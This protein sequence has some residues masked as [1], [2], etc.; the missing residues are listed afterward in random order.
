MIYIVDYKA[1]N[2]TS[3]QRALRALG[4][5]SALTPDPDVI[6]RADRVIF[7]GVGA[8]GAAMA[9]LRQ[10]G[11]D[12]ALVDA[13][14]R[15]IP[16]LGIC[17]GAQIILDRSEEGNTECV[18]LLPGITR[19]FALSDPMLKIPHMG[20]NRIRTLRH[21]PLLEGIRPEDEFYFV[22]SFYPDPASA[23]DIVAD[24]DYGIAFPVV[25]GRDNL[26]ATQ[27]HLEKSG[28]LGLRMLRN[29]VDWDGTV[30]HAQ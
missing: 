23:G 11:L 27:F 24:C 12:Q 29:F 22:H 8:A 16:I 26:I 4:V 10:T 25:I 3:V 20:W 14:A 13:R 15:G 2:V 5:E 17:L 21:H 9:V 6:R 7:P 18:G 19:R 1:G 30:P 28:P